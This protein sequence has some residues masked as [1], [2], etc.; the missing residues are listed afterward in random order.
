MLLVCSILHIRYDMGGNGGRREAAGELEHHAA[1][2][3]GQ[4]GRWPASQDELR[5]AGLG[6]GAHVSCM[7]SPSVYYEIDDDGLVL[8]RSP[9]AQPSIRPHGSEKL[10]GIIC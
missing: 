10:F 1:A 4:P 8:V 5:T 7:P 2:S 9:P 6:E 3:F